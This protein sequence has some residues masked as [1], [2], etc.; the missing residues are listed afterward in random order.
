MPIRLIGIP[1]ALVGY[2]QFAS[3][4]SR[5]TNRRL[6]ATSSGE[7]FHEPRLFDMPVVELMSGMRQSDSDVLSTDSAFQQAHERFHAP[8]TSS[9][10]RSD[11]F[12]DLSGE[13]RGLSSS[14]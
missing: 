14:L 4:L 8:D 1:I 5:G 9:L 13:A 6:R 7:N 10:I 11:S 2:Q 12:L 3:E